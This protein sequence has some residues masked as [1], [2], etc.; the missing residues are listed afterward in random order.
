[1]IVRPAKGGLD[2]GTF[3]RIE[4]RFFQAIQHQT[5]PKTGVEKDMQGTIKVVLESGLAHHGN[6]FPGSKV[7]VI[8]DLDSIG[9]DGLAVDHGLLGTQSC[10]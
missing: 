4:S 9:R 3:G 8:R 10:P 2:L 7:Q 5:S 6:A 1:M